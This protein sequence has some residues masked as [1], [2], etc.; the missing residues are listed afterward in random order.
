[1]IMN[2]YTSLRRAP[3]IVATVVVC[4]AL[5]AWGGVGRSHAAREAM[6]AN[7]VP[8]AGQALQRVLLGIGAQ[9]YACRASA[10]V[11]SGYEWTFT[12]P[13]A[14]LLDEAGAIAGTH[15][16]GPTWLGNDGSSVVGA[17]IEQAPSPDAAAV[18]WLLLQGTPSDATG[19]FSTVTYIQRLDTVGGV[20]PT[21]GCDEEHVGAVARVPYSAVYAVYGAP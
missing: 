16:G 14:V 17:V 3:L 4:T 21:A 12:A 7:L 10:T 9:V 1:M 15:F 6:P 2:S 8:P 13:S 5:A 20:A 19:I 11:S 18:P